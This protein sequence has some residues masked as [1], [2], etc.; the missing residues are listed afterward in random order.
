M[1]GTATLPNGYEVPN[2]LIAGS[3]DEAHSLEG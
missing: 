3:T 1:V 2:T